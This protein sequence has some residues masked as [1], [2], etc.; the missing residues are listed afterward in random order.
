MAESFADSGCWHST[1]M[2][3]PRGV[4]VKPV[5][6]AFSHHTDVLCS[7]PEA[8]LLSLGRLEGLPVPGEAG[9]PRW[10]FLLLPLC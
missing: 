5:P 6:S 2:W 3:R 8:A 4:R 1:N 10:L 7:I 9:G